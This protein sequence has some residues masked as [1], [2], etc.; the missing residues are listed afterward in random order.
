MEKEDRPYA[1]VFGRQVKSDQVLA[2][3]FPG[4]ADAHGM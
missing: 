2:D 1:D 4:L 3:V